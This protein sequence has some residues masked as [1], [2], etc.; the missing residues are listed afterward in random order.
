MPDALPA[1]ARL[2]V[3]ANGALVAHGRKNAHRDGERG[4]EHLLLEEGQ[5]RLADA[6]AAVLLRRDEEIEIPSAGLELL[7]EIGTPDGRVDCVRIADR[8]AA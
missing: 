5:R 3:G 8:L 7:R 2:L 1:E 4:R 6:L